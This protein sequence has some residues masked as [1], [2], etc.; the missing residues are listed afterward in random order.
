MRWCWRWSDGA[1][2]RHVVSRHVSR[3]ARTCLSRA[4]EARAPA[5]RR[6]S[7]DTSSWKNKKATESHRAEQRRRTKE[8]NGDK[9]ENPASKTLRM[10][11]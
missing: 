10:N 11:R 3:S 7:D 2:A 4:L 9:T 8:Q 5:L 6:T 1:L